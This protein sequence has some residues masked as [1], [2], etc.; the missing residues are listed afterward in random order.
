MTDTSRHAIVTGATK[1]IGR[2][3]TEALLTQGCEVLLVARTPGDVDAACAEL[4]VAHGGRA[5]GIAA[6]MASTEGRA[7]VIEAARSRWGRL[8]V[9]V[10]NAGT[11]VRKPT[12]DY[13]E[14]EIDKVIN[15]NQMAVLALAKDAYNLLVRG[16]E[17]TG[18]AAIVNIS[19]V[20]GF[21]SMGTGSPYAM[22][23]G[24]VDQT[25]R[26]LAVEWAPRKPTPENPSEP[27]RPG[28]RVNAVRPWY[29]RTPLVEPVFADSDRMNR[30]FDQTPMRR[31]GD[32]EE[33]A[34]L[35]AFLASPAASFVT[36]QCIACDGG[37][38]CQTLPPM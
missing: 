15:L 26:Y 4:N 14:A 25:S 10:N 37:A 35:V 30:V 27:K 6:D 16:S 23:K 19:S 7:S 8:E 22:T 13:T 20:A 34:A 5:H 1:G 32:P 24:A 36:G 11:N 3:I 17:A 9:L 29:I 33:V 21:T 31:V 18:D 38:S 2:A 28:V 12:Q